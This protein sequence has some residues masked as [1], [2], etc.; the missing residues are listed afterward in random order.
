M[1]LFCFGG[2]LFSP[3]SRLITL[4]FSQQG[5][6]LFVSLFLCFMIV[7]LSFLLS[8]GRV[9]EDDPPLFV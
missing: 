6:P 4:F 8:L 9:E 5:F 3:I 2:T 1:Q 7:F